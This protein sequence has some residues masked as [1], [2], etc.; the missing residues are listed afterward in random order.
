[1]VAVLLRNNRSRIA[2]ERQNLDFVLI[3]NHLAARAV[4]MRDARALLR[5]ALHL[6]DYREPAVVLHEHRLVVDGVV[7]AR[8]DAAAVRRLLDHVQDRLVGLVREVVPQVG[9]LVVDLVRVK[10]ALLANRL[11]AVLAAIRRAGRLVLGA[12][13]HERAEARYLLAALALR[14][15][16]DQVEVVRALVD[17][18]TGALRLYR[19]VAAA[20]G[21]SR[22]AVRNGR[23]VV[24]ARKL[25][26]RARRYN[27]AE[28]LVERRIAQDV[29]REDEALGALLGLC[30]IDALLPSAPDRLLEKDMVALLKRLEARLVVKAVWKRYDDG[31]CFD[32]GVKG[33]LPALPRRIARVRGK[34]GNRI[35]KPRDL[36]LVGMGL[37]VRLVGAPTYAVAEDY[38]PYRFH[39]TTI[40]HPLR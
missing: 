6:E 30:D 5:I 37:G 36:E 35:G 19:P 22:L 27:L 26:D 24:D 14:P 9:A 33:R 10:R 23:E 38:G 15:P 21:V 1:M 16:L 25:A 39:Q 8:I 7:A 31:V 11:G 12:P 29:P 17:E 3:G 28:L 13:V 40:S 34:F 20:I 32:A 18:H 4:E 2:E